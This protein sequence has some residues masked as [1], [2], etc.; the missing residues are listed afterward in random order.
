[1]PYPDKIVLVRSS[2]TPFGGVERVTLSLIK[3]L[4]GKGVAIRLLTLPGEQWPVSDARL[5]IVHLG[6]RRGHRLIKVWAFNRAVNH[7]L[8]QYPCQCV[9]ALD[10]VT[11]FTHLHAGGG[12][13][14]TF[15]EIKKRYSGAAARLF[16][17]FSLF[18]RYMIYLERKGFENR[19]LKKVRCN[20]R[21]VKDSIEKDYGVDPDKLVLVHSGI[22]WREMQTDFLRR[23]EVGLELCRRNGIDPNWKSLL[24]LGNGFRHKGLDVAI[25][26]LA[27]MSPQ[28]HLV[29]VGKGRAGPYHR[30]A[31]ASGVAGRVHFL[32]AQADGWRHACFCKAVVLP[33]QYDPF[34]GASAE[35]HAMG[36]PVLVSDKTGYADWVSHNENGIILKTPM[37]PQR[38]RESF[39]ALERLIEQPAWTPDQLRAHARNVDDDLILE[40]LL[41]FFEV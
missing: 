40:K 28:Y 23:Q 2:Y 25:R 39:A 8:D 38:V 33:S 4:L 15:L 34:G 3:G 29:V 31:K 32:G 20:S 17:R 16:L 30:L 7:H 41:K 24:F 10:K 14:K 37:H 26:G 35:G 12:T 19:G 9:L 5:K 21:M 22:R 11:R 6:F 27:V 18:H 1:M 36:L 13:H